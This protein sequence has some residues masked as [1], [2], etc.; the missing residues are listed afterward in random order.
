MSSI[1]KVTQFSIQHSD[2]ASLRAVDHGGQLVSWITRDG[3][4]RL[5]TS[6]LAQYGD[7]HAIRGGVPVIFPQ[8]AD[9]GSLPKHGLARQAQWQPLPRGH[10][11]ALSFVLRDTEWTHSI[12]PQAF[13]L[14]LTAT[15]HR[16]ALHLQLSIHNTGTVAWA[17]TAALHTYLRVA[18][19]ASVRLRGL[20]S[21]AYTDS[22]ASGRWVPA[23]HAPL[24]FTGEVDR[25]YGGADQPLTLEDPIPRLRIAQSGFTDVVVWNP[26]SERAQALRD[27]EPRGE[28]HLLCVE[29]AVVQQPIVLDAGGR[30]HGTQTLTAL[31]LS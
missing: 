30:W 15:L 1:D 4:E 19:I 21:S 16:D 25:V 10:D 8:F 26:G 7:R 22:T 14:D 12:W 27:L 17:F 31:D 18:D 3:C 24:R 13:Q 9:R 29:A 5:F 28:R 6:S 20:E 11:N 23:S 2:G